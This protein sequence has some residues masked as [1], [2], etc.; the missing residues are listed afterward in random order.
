M[1]SMQRHPSK[2]SDETVLLR[3]L[4]PLALA[5]VL[6]VGLGAVR[7]GLFWIASAV[8]GGIAIVIAWCT[9]SR[10]PMA[11]LPLFFFAAIGYLSLQPWLRPALPGNDVRRFID[12]GKWQVSGTV[13]EPPLAAGGNFRFVLK[14]RQLEQGGRV[15]AARGR[16]RVTARGDVPAMHRG[17]GVTVSGH[18]RDIRGFC[19]PGGFDYER[20]MALQG[21]HARLFAPSV[22][23]QA[24]GEG[25]DGPAWID[26]ARQRLDQ[27]M[28]AALGN[29]SE[30]SI[31]VLKALT[32]GRRDDLSDDLRDAFSR[33]GVSHVLAISGLHIGMVAA[34]AFALFVRLLAWIPWLLARAWVRKG[35]ALLSLFPVI[36]YGLLAALSPSTQRAMIMV[37]LFLSTSWIGRRHDWLNAAAA[38]ALAIL[39]VSPP[40][41]MSV[42]FQLSFSAVLAILL[43]LRVLPVMRPEAGQVL[44]RRWAR[45]LLIGVYVSVLANLGTAPLV[46]YYFNQVSWI[47]P[48]TNLVA[49]PLVG[50]VVV[51]A[52]LL[53]IALVPLSSALAG[54]CWHIAAWGVDAMVGFILSVDKLRGIAVTTVTPSLL[55]MALF[56]FLLAILLCWKRRTVR[57]IGLALVLLVGGLDAAYWVH[58]RFG[59]ERMVVTAVDVGQGSA[60]LLQLPGGFTVLVDGGGFGDNSTFDVGRSVLAP[61]LWRR[62]IKRIDLVILSHPNSDHLNGLL[63]I[64]KRFDVGRIWSNHEPEATQGFRQWCQLIAQKGISHESFD[65]LSRQTVLGGVNFEILA[66]PVDFMERHRSQPRHDLNN[67]S[68]VVRVSWND[69]SLLFTGDVLAESEAELVARHGPGKLYSTILLVP[70]HG[71][72]SSSTRIFM[73]AVRP[74]EGIISAGWKN[75]FRFPHPTV[76]ERY[77]DSGC[78]IWRTDRCGA[79]EVITDGRDYAIRTC[80]QRCGAPE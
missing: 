67:N 56:Y 28:S 31:Q 59:S 74:R 63:F 66:P 45:R 69:V 18:L 41:L 60:N 79:V 76:L 43:G 64:L 26:H 53:G 70:H 37:T 7:P 1:M 40:A 4:V 14:A 15:I 73:D 38:A 75:R 10:R 27:R 35:A 71:S 46:M 29:H 54:V 20:H 57:W 77:A 42:S 2:V 34:A 48:L 52:G 5:L 22:T 50:V 65:A 78:R 47:G 13:A 44:W 36:G 16:I 33:T 80:R 55:E 3:P 68:L 9:G 58:R 25:G 11:V 6:G 23:I 12:Q 19:N 49:V 21:I 24:Q 17:D 72:R 8:V 62:K 32:L 39:V 30:V 61:L 51:P